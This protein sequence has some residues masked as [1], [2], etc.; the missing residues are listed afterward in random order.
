MHHYETLVALEVHAGG[1]PG[2]VI[3]DGVGH[4]P[5]ATMFEKMYHL[6]D[7]PGLRE[8]RG[9]L[10]AQAPAEPDY[11]EHDG[12]QHHVAAAGERLSIAPAP[13]RKWSL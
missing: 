8:G 9:Q 3:V 1:E 2:R 11:H 13:S 6:R 12:H 4:V 7:R 10:A 5:G